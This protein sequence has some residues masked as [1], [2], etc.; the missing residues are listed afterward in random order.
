MLRT[1]SWQGALWS[2]VPAIDF[3]EAVS[4]MRW[5]TLMAALLGLLISLPLAW[6]LSIPLLGTEPSRPQGLP[7]LPMLSLEER[8]RLLTYERD[9]ETNADCDPPLGCFFNMRSQRTYC[10]DS[11]CATDRQCPKDF[12]CRT[13]KTKGGKSLVRVC[14][15]SG[16]RE[17]GELCAPLPST[18]EY[19]CGKGLL[20]KGRCGRPCRLEDPTSCP[21]GSFCEDGPDGPSCLPTCEG[22][23]CPEGQRCL[24]RGGRVSICATV[25]G[26]DCRRSPC[27]QGEVCMVYDY[28][29]PR[30]EVWMECLRGCGDKEDPPCPEGAIC[31]LYQCHKACTPGDPSV[32]GP[33]FT[34]GSRDH[35]PWT[36]V[37]HT[38]PGTR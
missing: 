36:C 12:V 38:S 30:D 34:C 35:A 27:P 24:S 4:S 28:P 14:S 17:E 10:T 8:L 29:Q 26:Q 33:G 9:C 1:Q 32:C 5:R 2:V 7:V 31:H 6:V 15:L 20:C 37:P 25:H 23:S 16:E 11:V 18:R 22:R 21:E 3:C 19:G 13:L